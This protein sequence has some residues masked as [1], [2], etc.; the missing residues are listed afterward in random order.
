MTQSSSQTKTGI[1]V[2]IGLLL[3]A[4]SVLYFGGN[5][6]ILKKYNH[7]KIRFSTA[8]GLVVGSVVSLAGIQVGHIEKIYFTKENTL[9][10]EISV[11]REFTHL[12]S[13]NSVASIR[14][15]GALG[16]KYIFIT[17][18]VPSESQLSNGDYIL[19]D[20]SVDIVEM[21]SNKLSELSV[22][23]EAIKELNLFLHNLNADGKS[24][25]VTGSIV[26]A[27]KG[28]SSLVND[29][30][31]R[32]AIASLKSILI[33]IDNG[34]GTLGQLINDPT[35]HNRLVN[36]IGEAPRNQYLKPLLRETIKQK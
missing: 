31:M 36:F 3:F 2:S 24:A 15:Q 10:A 1:F 13:A 33:K 29:S 22:A 11:Q 20:D 14:T 21:L 34:E 6:A 12:L 9:E 7:Y 28:V 17:S 18:G 30:N 19:T 26:D 8:Q 23:T 35:I 5:A 27:A 4:A 16:D 32:A 25:H